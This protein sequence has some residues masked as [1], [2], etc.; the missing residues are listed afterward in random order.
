[1][2]CCVGP[3][4]SIHES[5]EATVTPLAHPR[6]AVY[7]VVTG[8]DFLFQRSQGKLPQ[9][10][11]IIATINLTWSKLHKLLQVYLC[12]AVDFCLG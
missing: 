3:G 11:L 6:M 5:R 8:Y 10:G 4:M 2:Q 7:F 9:I 12:N 1:M